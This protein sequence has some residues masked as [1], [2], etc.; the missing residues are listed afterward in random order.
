MDVLQHI[1]ETWRP[2]IPRDCATARA[3]DR[4][5]PVEEI[6]AAATS[7]GLTDFAAAL[8]SAEVEV[9]QTGH[10]PIERDESLLDSI[11]QALAD[12]ESRLP[13]D[14]QTARLIRAG[15]RLEL[16]SEAA[17]AEGF[18][19]LA[20]VLFEAEQEQFLASGRD[21]DNSA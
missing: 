16:I 15:A 13:H 11:G 18:G 2:M 3:I 9:V 8:F 12:Y 4:Q 19:D 7:D 6:C 10:D 1:I 5:A 21:K 14:S 17:E 20:A